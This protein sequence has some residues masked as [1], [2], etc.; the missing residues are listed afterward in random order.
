MR[1]DF[2]GAGIHLPEIGLW[3]D[4]GERCQAAWM[5]HAH[6]D[7]ARG[8]HCQAFATPQTL[9]FYRLRWP[10]DPEFPQQLVPV[11]VR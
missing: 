8:L 4:P 6:S 7:H 1:I 10:E 5:S 2:A 11:P 3:L 9:H